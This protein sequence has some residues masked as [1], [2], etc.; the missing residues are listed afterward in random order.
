M[1]A[2]AGIKSACNGDWVRSMVPQGASR[3]TALLHEAEMSF[4]RRSPVG[5]LTR[6]NNWLPVLLCSFPTIG[7]NPQELGQV[8]MSSGCLKTDDALALG[9][10]TMQL[11][12]TLRKSNMCRS[13]TTMA[14]SSPANGGCRTACCCR[15]CHRGRRG[16]APW[17]TCASAPPQL[18]RRGHH[19]A[20]SCAGTRR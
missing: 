4:N 7:W 14:M 3:Q 11:K 19:H 18:A 10:D 16:T 5:N 20:A 15:R 6:S 2:R 9:R 12:V 1:S 13:M 17:P 8:K